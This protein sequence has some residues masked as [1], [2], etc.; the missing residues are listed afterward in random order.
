MSQS[1]LQIWYAR[2]YFPFFLL[3][4]IFHIILK[5]VLFSNPLTVYLMILMLHYGS[6]SWFAYLKGLIFSKGFLCNE[7]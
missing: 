6:Y 7:L 2:S 3:D 1:S 4:L 5:Q